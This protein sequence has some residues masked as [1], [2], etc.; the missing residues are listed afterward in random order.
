MSGEPT[1]RERQVA[2]FLFREE[3]NE[4]L[5]IAR[6]MCDEEG[7]VYTP[8]GDRCIRCGHYPDDIPF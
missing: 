3:D 8:G 7:H 2:A 1:P 4:R 5:R 6:Q